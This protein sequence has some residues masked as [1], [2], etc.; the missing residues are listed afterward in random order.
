M[1]NLDE[2]RIMDIIFDDI[3]SEE[4]S[5]TG[6]QKSLEKKGLNIHRL[7]LTGYLRALTEMG[8]INEKEIKPAKIYSI[9]KRNDKDIY[10]MVGEVARMDDEEES[11]NNAL[12]LLYSLFDRPVFMRELEKCNVS[13]PRDYRI[14]TSS[15]RSEYIKK[16]DEAGL[17]IP[18]SN[19]LIEPQ[20]IDRLKLISL[21]K[22]FIFQQYDLKKYCVSNNNQQRLD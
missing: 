17:K 22:N 9:I 6:I 2:K 3:G 16:L 4:K 10:S 14:V 15:Y 21:L 12:L 11:G 19:Q 8:M 1:N 18:K 20:N 13:Q 5:I 7:V